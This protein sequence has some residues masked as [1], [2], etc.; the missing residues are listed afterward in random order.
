VGN[1]NIVSYLLAKTTHKLTLNGLVV[2][3]LG[4]DSHLGVPAQTR[5]E[6]T[7]VLVPASPAA[8]AAIE[9]AVAQ[10]SAAYELDSVIMLLIVDDK[11]EKVRLKA[12][13]TVPV[14]A[15]K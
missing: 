15:R 8:G 7:T 6:R 13:G 10:G 1:P 12:A 2:G 3:T 4:D 9:Q 5:M 11:F 14:V